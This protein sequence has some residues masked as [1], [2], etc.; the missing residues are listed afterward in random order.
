MEQLEQMHEDTVLDLA[1]VRAELEASKDQATRQVGKLAGARSSAPRRRGTPGAR[2]VEGRQARGPPV[3]RAGP[4]LTAGAAAL[5]RRR[6]VRHHCFAGLAAP[7]HWARQQPPGPPG[8]RA[9]RA[10]LVHAQAARLREQADTMQRS[11]R[12]Q[13]GVL[14]QE[15][16]ESRASAATAHKEKE[17]VGHRQHRHV[18]PSWSPCPTVPS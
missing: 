17:E 8:P 18:A 14:E 4:P 9:N 1:R 10:I 7:S 2:Q 11:F 3:R 12:K 6:T 16:A 13:I 15:L 5:W